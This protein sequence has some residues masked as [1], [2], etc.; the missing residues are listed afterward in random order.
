MHILRAGVDSVYLAI[1]GTLPSSLLAQV[2]AAKEQAMAERRAIPFTFPGSIEAMI[3]SNGATGGYAFLWDTGLLGASWACRQAADKPDWNFFA[4]PDATALL[5]YGFWPVVQQLLQHVQQIGGQQIEH[6]INRIDYAIDIRADDFQLGL[7]NF[8][9]H[10]RTK[11]GPHWESGHEE[12]SSA[13]FTGRRLESVTVG[14]LPGRQII[15]YDKTA[16]ARARQKVHFFEA[17]GIDPAD[18]DAR[19]WR[20][21]LRFGKRELKERQ[22][23]RMVGNLAT[24]LRP[25]LEDLLRHVRYVLPGQTDTNVSRCLLHPLWE[26]STKHV[27]QAEL[28]TGS[29]E[30]EPARLMQVT[31]DMVIERRRKLLIG[32]AAGLGA[33][34]DLDDDAIKGNLSDIVAE[35]IGTALHEDSFWRSVEKARERSHLLQVQEEALKGSP[36]TDAAPPNY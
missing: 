24:D 7:D 21:E 13:V 3:A 28:L 1:K 25:A 18:K 8:V 30:I 15:V 5:A 14:R 19:V 33:T 9:A 6:S 34:M 35:A 4:K 2:G 36:Q 26:L 10:A 23:I 31:R 32:N 17:W 11:R 16:E 12:K 27:Q 22:G 20:V 29:G